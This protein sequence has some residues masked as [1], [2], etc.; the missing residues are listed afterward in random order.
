[1]LQHK[2]NS[3]SDS[4]IYVYYNKFSEEKGSE[5]ETILLRKRHLM[6]KRRELIR[7]FFFSIA[8]RPDV[9]RRVEGFPG[10][11]FRGGGAGVARG[12]GGGGARGAVVQ[13]NSRG[14]VS[15]WH[16][17]LLV[18]EQPGYGVGSWRVT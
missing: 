6:K 12:G 9:S 14:A 17:A 8:R 16:L 7:R 18:I 4:R 1:M 11:V 15:R 10:V 13:G 5:S 3:F 2:N